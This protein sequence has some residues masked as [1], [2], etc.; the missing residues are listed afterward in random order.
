MPVNLYQQTS[1]RVGNPPLGMN[2]Q[3]QKRKA[4]TTNKRKLSA[5]NIAY[6]SHGVIKGGFW[7]S[8]SHA[9]LQFANSVLGDGGFINR[10]AIYRYDNFPVTLFQQLIATRSRGSL[11]LNQGIGDF[12]GGT[13]TGT[14]FP[15]RL[16]A[17][18]YIGA[19]SVNPNLKFG[20]W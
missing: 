5:R 15:T 11:A 13:P 10:N 19:F 20:T 12:G 14:H 9:E 6:H 18:A 1:G 7:Y 17:G 2:N 8:D 3:G 4:V 16:R